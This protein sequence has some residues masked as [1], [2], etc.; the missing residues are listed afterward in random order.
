MNYSRV[1]FQQKRSR[2]YHTFKN[3][4]IL[5][6]THTII[7]VSCISSNQVNNPFTGCQSHDKL[8]EAKRHLRI[9]SDPKSL[10]KVEDPALLKLYDETICAV[11]TQTNLL[12]CIPQEIDLTI[13]FTRQPGNLRLIHGYIDRSR[14]NISKNIIALTMDPT[15]IG[16]L[17][18]RPDIASI[19]LSQNGHIRS[20]STI[21]R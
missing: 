18:A 9:V 14:S 13:K 6:T 17:I 16:E 5:L 7:F 12:L 2:A 4:L 10:K 15:R 21:W 3:S 1:K 19:S 8:A 11:R 20:P